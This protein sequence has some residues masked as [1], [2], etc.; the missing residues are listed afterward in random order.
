M[1]FNKWHYFGT[2]LARNWHPKVIFLRYNGNMEKLKRDIQ[3][4]RINSVRWRS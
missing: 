3:K 4:K 2:K 1:V